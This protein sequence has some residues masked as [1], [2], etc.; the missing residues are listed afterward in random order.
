MTSAITPTTE[1]LLRAP[2]QME[3]GTA[4]L[5]RA[6]WLYLTLMLTANDAGLVIRPT[7]RIANDLA[8]TDVEIESWLDRLVHAGLVRVLSRSPYLTLRLRF[9]PANNPSVVENN[10]AAAGDPDS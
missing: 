1:A 5:G 8:V 9:W 10:A 3:G 7:A 4:R 2:L 6:L